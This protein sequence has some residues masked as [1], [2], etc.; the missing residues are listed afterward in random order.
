MSCLTCPTDPN[1]AD[2]ALLLQKSAL[3]AEACIFEQEKLLR[4][5]VNRPTV[6]VS[7]TTTFAASNGSEGFFTEF[8]D[9]V[10]IF[11]NANNLDGM[12]AWRNVFLMG[13]IFLCGV[14][15]TATAATPDD[16]TLRRTS[17]GVR[18]VPDTGYSQSIIFTQYET[19]AANGVDVSVAAVF[20]VEP[21]IVVGQASLLVTNTSSAVTIGT[22]ALI[23]ATRLGDSSIVRMV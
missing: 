8:I 22:G 21:N 2:V 14:N 7:S 17:L 6:L 23:W 15:F 4:S 11:N 9:A 10:T 18:S 20:A 1:L 19:T 16:N 12:N 13:G 5:A 3:E